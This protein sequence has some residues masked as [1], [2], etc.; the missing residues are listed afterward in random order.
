MLMQ[1]GC[2]KR[3][4]IVLGTEKKVLAFKSVNLTYPYAI[5]DK[6]MIGSLVF[7]F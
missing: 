3:P 6:K 1:L 2:V 5:V 4:L 7:Y